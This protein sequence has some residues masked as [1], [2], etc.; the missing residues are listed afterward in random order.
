MKITGHKTRSMFDRYN[1]VN[2]DDIRAA[3]EKRAQARLNDATNDATGA[4]TQVKV[5]EQPARKPN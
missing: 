3:I 2:S 4:K 5:E 1:I